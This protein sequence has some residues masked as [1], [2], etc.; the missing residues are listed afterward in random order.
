MP[1]SQGQQPVTPTDRANTLLLSTTPRVTFLSSS[2]SWATPLNCT[3]SLRCCERANNLP[4]F[5]NWIFFL[6]EKDKLP[7]ILHIWRRIHLSVSK[8]YKDIYS[9]MHIITSVHR[10][11]LR[12]SLHHS[13]RS[14]RLLH[15][16]GLYFHW[17]K[18][19]R[20]IKQEEILWMWCER[21]IWVLSCCGHSSSAAV[22]DTD[23]KVL[24]FVPQ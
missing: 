15:L 23:T 19:K 1:D 13:L 14:S 7:I 9:R 24:S 4:W 18:K 2:D 20:R 16:K 11:A 17:K 22:T 12:V 21:L 10:R 5:V 8:P 6:S 3:W